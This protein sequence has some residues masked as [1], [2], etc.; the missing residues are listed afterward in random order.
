MN[1]Q[2]AKVLSLIELY[3][4]SR[5]LWDS[6]NADYYKKNVKDEAWTLISS[7]IDEPV[8]TC[9]SKIM[10]L[11]ASYRREKGKVRQTSTSA[12]GGYKSRW[13]AYEALKFLEERETSKKKD[14]S[15]NANPEDEGSNSQIPD[16]LLT[17]SDLLLVK[18]EPWF[19]TEDEEVVISESS[20]NRPVESS[21]RSRKRTKRDDQSL[22]DE[23]YHFGQFLASKLRSY[24]TSTRCAIQTDIM[25][26]LQRV[27]SGNNM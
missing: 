23:C 20:E 17:D 10:S 19:E 15:D 22:E 6:K 1:W 13:F 4:T 5:V 24:D 12:D 26:I 2:S 21:T 25:N 16:D 8:E 9:K 11:L 18:S 14:G 27:D 7:V 3:K